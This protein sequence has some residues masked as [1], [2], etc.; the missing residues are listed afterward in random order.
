MQSATRRRVAEKKGNSD[1]EYLTRD[2]DEGR[3]G[4]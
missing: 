1:G 3:M 2:M 4:R